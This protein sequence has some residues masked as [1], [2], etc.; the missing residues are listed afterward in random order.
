MA[1]IR[2]IAKAKLTAMALGKW[3]G[4]DPELDIQQDHV[5][6]YWPVEK[7]AIAQDGFSSA[8]QQ[9]D[10]NIRVDLVPVLMPV[11]TKKYGIYAAGALLSAFLLGRN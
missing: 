7:L 6:I 10:K 11:L 5:R 4:V 3:L 8:M 9:K 1:D 2:D